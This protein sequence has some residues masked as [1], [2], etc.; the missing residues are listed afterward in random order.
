MLAEGVFSEGLTTP[1]N[2]AA[3]PGPAQKI[4]D[5]N[6][7]APL[8]AMAAKGLV[9]GLKP[10][11]VLFDARRRWTAKVRPDGTLIS[12]DAKGSI[13]Q[14]AAEVQ[15]APSCNGWEFWFVDRKGQP[16]PIEAFRQQIR[17]EMAI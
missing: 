17:A 3:L 16:V 10:G 12:A 1:I 6:G 9:P 8:K 14:V 2:V 4:L 7:P 11:E 13:H 15:G 5:P